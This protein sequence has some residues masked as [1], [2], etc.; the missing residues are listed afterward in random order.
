MILQVKQKIRDALAGA[1]SG[2]HAGPMR[3]MYSRGLT[4]PWLRPTRTRTE[5]W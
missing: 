1:G 5:A 4:S 2:S 3:G